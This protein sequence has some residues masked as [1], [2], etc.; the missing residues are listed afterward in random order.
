MTSV[1]GLI[2][3]AFTYIASK[4]SSFV[5]IN[6]AFSKS[7]QI[8]CTN[9]YF[10]GTVEDMEYKSAAYP[11]K[12]LY[13][14]NYLSFIEILSFAF[15]SHRPTSLHILKH[16]QLFPAALLAWFVKLSHHVEH[17]DVFSSVMQLM[18]AK[19]GI[20]ET[21]TA[22]IPAFQVFIMWMLRQARTHH[23]SAAFPS[24]PKAI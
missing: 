16:F 15:P 6:H 12:F 22:V 23:P 3:I 19:A 9:Y 10:E 24:W 8:C 17:T 14:H 1:T 11:N 18:E 21:H 7:L 5:L 20:I 4:V 13:F 2:L